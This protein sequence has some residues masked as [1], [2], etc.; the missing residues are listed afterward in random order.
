MSMK[1]KVIDF[2]VKIPV[3][4]DDVDC[5]E[6]KEVAL[7]AVTPT[8]AQVNEAQS[9]YNGGFDKAIRSK[10][11]LRIE[12]EK[13]LKDRGIWTAAQTNEIE[14]LKKEL[15]LKVDRLSGGG[16]KL[17]EAKAL[18]LEIKELRNKVAMLNLD[19]RLLDSNTVEAQ[20]EIA[21][22]NWYVAQCVVYPDTGKPFFSSLE[23]YHDKMST[24]YAQ[25]CAR[26]FGTLQYGVDSDF[27]SRLPEHKFLVKYGFAR[28]KDFKLINKQGK[29]V[30]REGHLIDENGFRLDA[31]GRQINYA[32]TAISKEG[33]S[34]V[35]VKPFLDE[36]GSPLVDASFA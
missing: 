16:M 29:L 9:A 24:E 35:E 17:G 5:K 6:F 26:Q 19:R 20:A 32:G 31:Q 4:E 14:T 11:P 18:A 36:D 27:E 12:V 10:A 21:R 34:L 15:S 1:P 13:L 8:A 33:E 25:E 28:E 22:F 7:R 23:D 2:T 3:D 30:D